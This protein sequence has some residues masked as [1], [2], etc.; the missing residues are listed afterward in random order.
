MVID[1][2][3]WG[4]MDFYTWQAQILHVCGRLTI[5]IM[6]FLLRRDI[7]RP[8]IWAG[9]CPDWCFSGWFPWS[10]SIYSFIKSMNIGSDWRVAGSAYSLYL[11]IL[12]P[13]GLEE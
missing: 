8:P 7:V 3:A 4:F 5:P 13:E 11:Y 12:L 2:I 9:M 6:C 10:L 1:H